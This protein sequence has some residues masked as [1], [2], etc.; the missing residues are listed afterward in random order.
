MRLLITRT[1]ERLLLL[2]ESCRLPFFDFFCVV[3]PDPFGLTEANPDIGWVCN[4]PDT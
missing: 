4:D 3:P 1:I 2:V